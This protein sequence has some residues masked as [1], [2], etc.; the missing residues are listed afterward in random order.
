MATKLRHSMVAPGRS[1]LA[2]LVERGRLANRVR[3][4]LWRYYPQMLT[5][6]DDLAA[7][8][9]LELWRQAPTPAKAARARAVVNLSPA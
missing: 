1:A 5:L 4:Q 2:G 7:A 6:A 8:W 3:E 9:F